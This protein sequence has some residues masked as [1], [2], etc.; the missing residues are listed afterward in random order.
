MR[1]RPLNTITALTI[2]ICLNF[3]CNQKQRIHNEERRIKE[4]EEIELNPKAISPLL[5]NSYLDSVFNSGQVLTVEK[6]VIVENSDTL[7]VKLLQVKDWSD[8]GDFLRIQIS[9]PDK[10]IIFDQKNLD[11]WT[12]HRLRPETVLK[13]CIKS[14][15]LL[16]IENKSGI[17]LIL[18]G[19]TY[20]SQPGIMTIVDLFPT[21]KIV[22]NQ[23]FELDSLNLNDKKYVTLCGSSNFIDKNQIE[24][25][26][27]TINRK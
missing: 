13:S 20:A 23:P 14:D 26:T 12:K 25:K 4:Y 5:T 18:F 27:W 9:R 10:S 1:K 15:N 16:C 7:I 24:T 2:L 8:P 6:N 21:P 3:S 19:Y 22:F 11:G 17:Q